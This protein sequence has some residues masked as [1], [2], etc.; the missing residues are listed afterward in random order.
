M[1]I[2]PTGAK[3]EIV[4]DEMKLLVII[5]A[6]MLFVIGLSVCGRHDE[7]AAVDKPIAH[8]RELIDPNE[9]PAY[10]FVH[11]HSGCKLDHFDKPYTSF[12]NYRGV[13]H[14]AGFEVWDCKEDGIDTPIWIDMKEAKD[15]K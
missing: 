11:S 8:V 4:S 5:A 9:Y 15:A 12:S 14:R 3:G 10:D 7:V 1:V 13:V 6:L 2:Y